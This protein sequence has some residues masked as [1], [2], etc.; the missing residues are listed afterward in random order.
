LV[1]LAEQRYR[2]LVKKW[3]ALPHPFEF[4][5]IDPNWIGFRTKIHSET[6]EATGTKVHDICTI[7]DGDWDLNRTMKTD[8]DHDFLF[9]AVFQRYFHGTEWRETGIIQVKLRALA[10]SPTGVIDGCRSEADFVA[11][12]ARLDEVFAAIY[13]HGFQS[14]DMLEKGRIEEEMFVSIGRFGTVFF[15]AGGNHRLAIA[16]LLKLP[17]IPCL[18]MT[19]HTAWQ[20]AKEQANVITTPDWKRS[21]IARHPDH[22]EYRANGNEW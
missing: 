18:V 16:K 8:L 1:D 13:K 7:R 5:N 4:I 14:Q 9:N 19:R 22:S 2:V 12:Y 10:K 15:S 3:P 6:K 21:V 17:T 11:R 20:D